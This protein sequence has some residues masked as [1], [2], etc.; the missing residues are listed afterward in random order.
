MRATL[1][2]FLIGTLTAMSACKRADPPVEYAPTGTIR[3]V[4]KTIVEPS[5][6]FVWGSFA[7]I[8]TLKGE[9]QKVPRT[10]EEWEGVR[11]HT[12]ALVEATNLLLIPNRRVA[13]PGQP[14]DNPDIER[15]P[16]DIE[17]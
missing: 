2:T 11:N 4:M 16:K 6:D 14:A 1:I 13:K 3:E 8:L 15:D 9:E 7:T 10:D 5:A 12:I 17:A